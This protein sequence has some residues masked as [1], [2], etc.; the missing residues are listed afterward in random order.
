MKKLIT[1][2]LLLLSIISFGQEN[3]YKKAA[4]LYNDKNYS[5]AIA[6]SAKILNNEYGNPDPIIK[7]YTSYIIADS[8]KSL[9]NYSQAYTKFKE[10]LAI[11]DNSSS[12]SRKDLEKAKNDINKIIADLQTKILNNENNQIASNSKSAESKINSKETD[13]AIVEEINIKKDSILN[14]KTTTTVNTDKTVTLTVSGSGKTQDEAKQMALRSAIEQAF[15]A[16]IS[17]KT[18]I[19]NDQVV[20]DQ[21]SS[22]ASGNIQS[23]EMLNESQLPD[24]SWG[25]TLRAIVSVDKLQSFVQAKGIAIEI[26]GGL[27]AIN[28][29]QQILNEQSENIAISEMFG[30]LHETLQTSFDYEIKA[31]EPQ[32]MDAASMYWEIPITVTATA[33]KNIDF[34]ASYCIK[35]LTSLSMSPSE[36]DRYRSSNKNTYVVLI[37][38][39]GNFQSFYLRNKDSVAVLDILFSSWE[40][41]IGSCFRIDGIGETKGG[42]SNINVEYNKNAYYFPKNGELGGTFKGNDI[43]S[44]SKISNFKGYSI[45][46]SGVFSEYKSGGIVIE[47]PTNGKYLLGLG[48]DDNL[49][50]DFLENDYPAI[51]AGLQKEDN[52]VSINNT[53]IT[54]KLKTYQLIAKLIKDGLKLQIVINRDGQ[55]ITKDIF[56]K[57]LPPHKGLVVALTDIEFS[58]KGNDFETANKKCNELVINNYN[59]WTIPTIDE[60]ES[61]NQKLYKLNFN[62]FN[63]KFYWSSSDSGGYRHFKKIMYFEKKYG[64]NELFKRASSEDHMSNIENLGSTRAVRYF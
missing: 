43:K 58:D 22:V 23:Y 56:P 8:Y 19:L 6:I 40:F 11:L 36:V 46:S 9:E 21:I 20:A 13:K 35:I 5:E 3:E 30:V 1:T 59:D 7:V 41:Y 47:E 60:L 12:F 52:I 2:L 64:G 29:K 17:S 57:Y 48:I 39:N 24:G 37:N 33:N 63:K 51:L 31:A 26:N 42:V 38:Y 4:T 10:Y 32:A 16:F 61:I 49:N 53:K 50:I 44:L 25:I 27:F 28:I 15:G 54:N 34:C 55:Y 14:E 62:G 18:E 45:K